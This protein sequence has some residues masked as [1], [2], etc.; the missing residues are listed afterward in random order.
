LARLDWRCFRTASKIV[1]TFADGLHHRQSPNKNAPT[2]TNLA[3]SVRAPQRTPV[4]RSLPA[5]APGVPEPRRIGLDNGLYSMIHFVPVPG[6]E[7]RQLT[8]T[9]HPPH[10]AIP[11]DA[12]GR[13][14]LPL[15][16]NPPAI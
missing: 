3:T 9:H 12:S 13:F 5:T 1:H 2:K 7:K 6:N 16:P 8:N 4:Q 10:V 11:L 14:G 15:R